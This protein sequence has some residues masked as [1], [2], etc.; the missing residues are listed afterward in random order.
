MLF[1]NAFAKRIVVD[2]LEMHCT[3]FQS[4]FV[5]EMWLKTTHDQMAVAD[6]V[7][8]FLST[9][10]FQF[11]SA[12]ADVMLRWLEVGKNASI[13][14]VAV[15]DW[16]DRNIAEEHSLYVIG[17]WLDAGGETEDVSDA[18][19]KWMEIAGNITKPD[20]DLIYSRWLRNG[21][22]I[23]KVEG[24]V[25]KWLSVH[26]MS[27]NAGSLLAD[28]LKS[29]ERSRLIEIANSARAK[30]QVWAKQ[31]LRASDRLGRMTIGA[32][33]R[34]SGDPRI[35]I[36]LVK[37]F[38]IGNPGSTDAGWLLSEI[39]ARSGDL[40]AWADL[41]V[42]WFEFPENSATEPAGDLMIT[43]IKYGGDLSI[44]V[45]YVKPW[46]AKWR[47]KGTAGRLLSLLIDVTRD[48]EVW[49]PEVDVW[50]GVRKNSE[51][52]AFPLVLNSWLRQRGSTS[53]FRRYCA[54][55][56]AD[57]F[58]IPF[59]AAS[60]L[61][62]NQS[63][64]QRRIENWFDWRES[65]EK[66][67]I[68]RMFI[69][70]HL[71]GG[72]PKEIVEDRF[73]LWL[74]AQSVKTSNVV[75][76][77]LGA[78]MASGGSET[79]LAAVLAPAFKGENSG[80]LVLR[81]SLLMPTGALLESCLQWVRDN[82]TQSDAIRAIQR[83]LNRAAMDNRERILDA[84]IEVLNNIA[85]IGARPNQCVRA[86]AVLGRLLFE[87]QGSPRYEIALNLLRSWLNGSIF[88]PEYG[89]EPDTHE[90]SLVDAVSELR[91]RGLID[92]FQFVRFSL[93]TS[94]WPQVLRRGHIQ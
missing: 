62:A 42:Q 19:D 59:G 79:K 45:D 86:I 30:F 3:Q 73:C 44:V 75:N 29:A 54:I 66:P 78:W 37:P 88:V 7:N 32:W 52:N 60:A 21:G 24:A 20:A 94:F 92:E 1:R 40:S 28:I 16:L 71:V 57:T 47:G 33:L 50:T 53:G 82:V 34:N 76:L 18:L 74:D 69:V 15:S 63:L 10:E 61:V 46:L 38:I 2:W 68:V 26:D 48:V 81:I 31:H 27:P 35:V 90:K 64:I 91:T 8:R 23:I 58:E 14:R 80:D 56:L 65:I 93:F 85:V 25:W 49:A 13:I 6:C 12:A 43:W 89:I 22:S 11:S 70:W 5:L 83:L 77:L 39:V 4:A 84:T 72:P 55:A 67:D 36:E 41:I 51:S 87:T 17:R 9:E